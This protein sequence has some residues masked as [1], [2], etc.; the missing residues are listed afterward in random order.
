MILTFGGGD[1]DYKYSFISPEARVKVCLSG[2]GYAFDLCRG[3][4]VV[5]LKENR[6]WCYS[7]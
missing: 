6:W 7:F 4:H 2:L 5:E 1:I 3:L